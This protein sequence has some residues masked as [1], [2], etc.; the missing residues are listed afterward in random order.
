MSENCEKGDRNSEKISDIAERVAKT[1]SKSDS[2]VHR[3]NSH[4]ERIGKVEETHSMFAA[5][6]SDVKNI[7]KKIEKQSKQSAENTKSII[8]AL[9]KHNKNPADYKRIFIEGVTTALSYAAVSLLAWVVF[10]F[11]KTGGN[12]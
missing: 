8:E 3:L 4:E 9:T 11:M 10:Q 2:N 6:K 7:D 1:E 5:L 12:L